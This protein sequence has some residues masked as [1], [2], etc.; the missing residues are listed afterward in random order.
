M[1]D[2]IYIY[3]T[4]FLIFSALLLIA[5]N[6]KKSFCF[7]HHRLTIAGGLWCL[8]ERA[9]RVPLAHGWF[10]AFVGKFGKENQIQS[11]HI[12]I[13]SSIW[14][15]GPSL[16]FNF[17]LFKQLLR[18]KEPPPPAKR[19]EPWSVHLIILAAQVNLSSSEDFATCISVCR[20]S[21]SARETKIHIRG[22]PTTETFYIN[23][24]VAQGRVLPLCR[25]RFYAGP[26]TETGGHLDFEIVCLQLSCFEFE[27]DIQCDWVQCFSMFF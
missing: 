4:P 2:N 9:G 26:E 6:Q 8:A 25:L 5:L 22:H 17:S 15:V 11:N 1:I 16:N 3:Y 20:P 19:L 14:F 13:Q 27:L 10:G 12:E 23:R 18:E 21:Y 7:E 24:S